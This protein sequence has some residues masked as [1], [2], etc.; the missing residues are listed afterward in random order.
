M[1][2]IDPNLPTRRHAIDLRIDELILHGFPVRDRHRIAAALQRELSRLIAQG[3]LAHLPPNSIQLDRIDAGSFR[4]D[5]A[6]GPN[7]IG[8]TVAQRVYRQ[9]SPGVSAT[10]AQ[11]GGGNHA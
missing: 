6:A 2:V 5:P 8:R 10:P 3:D 11:S 4:L 7:H 1:D 9:L